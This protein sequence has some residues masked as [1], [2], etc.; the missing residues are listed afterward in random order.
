MILLASAGGVAVAQ[1]GQPDD[2]G[3]ASTVCATPA[4]GAFV[5]GAGVTALNWCVSDHGNL[6]QLTSPAGFEHIR[7]GSF[8]EG[9]AI[10]DQTT[11]AIYYDWGAAE[12]ANWGAS[13]IAISGSGA[14]VTRTTADGVWRLVMTFTRNTGEKEIN[15][16]MQL[17]N[18]S[19]VARVVRLTRMYDGDI[20]GDTGDDNWNRTAESTLASDTAPGHALILTTKS[21]SIIHDTSVSG[22][23]TAA[24]PL[25]CLP[26]SIA[27]PA[28]GDNMGW[29]MHG[30]LG[31]NGGASKTVNVQYNRL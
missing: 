10:C 14:T 16:K 12:S 17:F 3:S 11:G 21:H 24:P 13:G 8:V 23:S 20:D 5:F 19:G 2:V 30:N 1:G 29:L 6:M 18:L 7:I 26:P 31:I 9:Y 27:T 15:I 22:F 28:V 4:G 25:A